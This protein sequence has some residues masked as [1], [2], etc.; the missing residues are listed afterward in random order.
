[1]PPQRQ[2]RL[3]RRLWDSSF[4]VDDCGFDSR[5][6]T[7]FEHSRSVSVRSRCP[8]VI[9]AT[10]VALSPAHVSWISLCATVLQEQEVLF[11]SGNVVYF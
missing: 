6:S 3:Q 1:M 8:H 2:A 9:Q 5:T 7:I 10:N 11:Q 4:A